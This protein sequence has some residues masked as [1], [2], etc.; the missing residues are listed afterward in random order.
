MQHRK[1]Y[2]NIDLT[3]QRFGRLEVISK[4]PK[5]RTTF[6]C[7]CDCG[8][9][10]ILSVSRLLGGT[11]SC[12]C[13][14]KETQSEFGKRN[15]KHGASYTRLYHV[16]R[17]MI[18]R[19]YSKNCRNYPSYGGRGIS[20]CDEWRNS[21]ESF[22]K[23]AY[24]NSYDDSISGHDQSLD[25]IDVNGNYCPE[26]C[27]WATA[28][29]QQEN[30]R[31]TKMYDFRGE[32]ITA[33]KFAKINGIKDVSIVYRKLKRGISLEQILYEF[34]FSKSL[35]EGVFEVDSVASEMGICRESVCRL[36]REG[37]LNG[38]KVG[39]KWYVVK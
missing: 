11:K 31:I 37:K 21:F 26:N 25:R 30:R 23:W 13:L 15:I 39:K 24:N 36:I 33:S 20:V 27:R 38:K 5:G 16:Y 8:R 12:G 19:C 7:K 22:R 4:N 10:T 32:Q 18:D 1:N 14:M 28:Q 3:G 2:K 9:E 6:L 34:N 35:P 29:Q 17:G